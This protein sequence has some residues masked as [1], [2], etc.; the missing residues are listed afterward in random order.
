MLDTIECY[1]KEHCIDFASLRGT[2]IKRGEEVQRFN[3]DQSCTVFV[4]SLGAGGLGIDLTA[5]SCVIHYDRWWNAAR[6][7]QAT[8]RVH[9]I[10][11]TRGVQVFKLVTKNTFEER[12][13]KMIEKKRALL[14]DLVMVDDHRLIRKFSKSELLSLFTDIGKE[15][16]YPGE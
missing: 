14:E 8:D 11:Q 12:I 16:I 3:R 7:D 6:E 10:G 5:A 9:R 15:I 13:E 4:A 2:T 1:L